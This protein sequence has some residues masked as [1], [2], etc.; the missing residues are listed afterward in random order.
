ME[1]DSKAHPQ[2]KSWIKE[3]FNLSDPTEQ[4]YYERK[5]TASGEGSNYER[6]S[7]LAM[8]GFPTKHALFQS[9]KKQEEEEQPIDTKAK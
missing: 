7:R 2:K 1:S 9:A 4:E 3:T 5:Y 6:T 8:L